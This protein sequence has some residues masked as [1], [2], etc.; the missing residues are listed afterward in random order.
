MRSIF[1][2][3]LFASFE[4]FAKLPFA[5]IYLISDIIYLI[6]Y[7]IV[8]YRKEVV[9]TN[10]KNS[11]PEKSE[12]EI[13]AIAKR[14]Y[15][16]LADTLVETIKI[17]GMD[18]EDFQHRVS[19][20]N[21]ELLQQLYD[22]GKSVV[23]FCSHYG[24]WEWVLFI[25][26]MLKHKVLPIY[27]PLNNPYSDTYFRTLRA[28][29]GGIPTPM[30]ETLR[31]LLNYKK[32]N[33]LTI[34]WLAADQT[35]AVEGAYWAKFLHQDTPF[36]TGGEKIAKKLQQPA[37]FMYIKKTGR[38]YYEMGFELMEKHPENLPE[39]A[40]T[41]QYVTILEKTIQEEPAYW[42]WSHKRWKHKRDF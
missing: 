1:Y 30:S 39:N 28:K 13:K 34:V 11:F 10:L 5:V 33:Q 32:Q 24:N 9:F 12:R 7:Q 3:L 35:P 27:Q 40:L 23:M 19:I 41:Q 29:F 37:V 16:H 18:F 8:G 4:L 42:L 31:A 2:N 22:E 21:I 15:R 36:Y 20:K 38:G 17:A 25:C 6:V 26:K 14:F